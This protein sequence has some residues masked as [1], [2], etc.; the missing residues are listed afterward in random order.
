[1]PTVLHD[2]G[3]LIQCPERIKLPANCLLVTAA[4]VSSLY[5]NIDTKKAIIPLDLL[6]SEGNVAQTA[7]LVQLTRLVFENNFLQSEFSCDVRNRYGYSLC[8]YSRK[9]IYVLP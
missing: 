5:P 1:M 3:E 9:R 2:S 4:D 7:L 6:L 8:C